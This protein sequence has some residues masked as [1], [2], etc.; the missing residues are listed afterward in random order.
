VKFVKVRL[1]GQVIHE[2]V[3]PNGSTGGALAAVKGHCRGAMPAL[4]S[5]A[6]FNSSD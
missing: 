6:L 2:N 3:E 1:N 4:R 5:L